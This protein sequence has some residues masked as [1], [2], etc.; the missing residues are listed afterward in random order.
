MEEGK[1]F[2]AKNFIFHF[3]VDTSNYFLDYN[4]LEKHT[5]YPLVKIWR[6]IYLK[7]QVYNNYK[8]IY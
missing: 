5:H 8:K 1:N 6:K 3:N 2:L 7:K 4:F